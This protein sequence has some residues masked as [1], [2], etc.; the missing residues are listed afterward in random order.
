MNTMDSELITFGQK[1]L[2]AASY[3]KRIA[4][5]TELLKD[6]SMWHGHKTGFKRERTILENKLKELENGNEQ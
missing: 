1:A 2:L 4:Q 6:Q 3:R 5:I